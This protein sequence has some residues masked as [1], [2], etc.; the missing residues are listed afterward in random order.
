M[1][2]KFVT[3]TLGIGAVFATAASA[4]SAPAVVSRLAF[5]T[6]NGGRDTVVLSNL[7]G[8]GRQRMGAGDQPLLSPDGRSVAASSFNASGPALAIYAVGAPARRYLD[9]RKE[10]AS[11]VSWSPDSRFLA[12]EVFGSDVNGKVTPSGIDVVDTTTNTIRTISG[13]YPCGAS[14]APN[15]PDRLVYASSPASSFCLKRR[16][17]VFTAASDGSSRKQLTTDGS[18]LN[19]VF[20][21]NSIA[22]DRE[23]L[24]RNDAPVFQIWLMNPDGSHRRQ[25]TRQKVPPLLDGLVPLQFDAAGDRLLA[26]FEGQDTTGTYTIDVTRRHVRRLTVGRSAVE[27]RGLSRDGRSVLVDVGAFMNPPSSGKVATIPFSGGRAS[28]LVARAAE[29]SWDR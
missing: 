14:F 10:T 27:P 11:A 12:V 4:A 19:P 13:G 6:G 1:A 24:R 21:A 17:N 28:V 9:V 16:V 8:T 26:Q 18:S 23:T 22:F 5:V 3:L 29:P 7:N 2:R 15:L 25:L 20:G